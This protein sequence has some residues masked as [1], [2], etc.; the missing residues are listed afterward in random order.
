MIICLFNNYEPVDSSAAAIASQ[1]LFRL[2]KHMEEIGDYE[3]SKK[4]CQAGLT[5]VKN[6]LAEKYLSLDKNHQGLI[7]HSIYH[8]PK[9]WDHIPEGAKVP[10]GESSMWGDYHAPNFKSVLTK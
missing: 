3:A 2:G 1:G 9:G 8:Y 5:V 10:H 7:L 4:Y 6:L